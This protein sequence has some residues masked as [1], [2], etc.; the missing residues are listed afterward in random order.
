MEPL[1]RVADG[2]IGLAATIGAIGL[3]VEIG[4]ILTDV[5]GRA[6]GSPLL[7]SQDFITM[8]LVIVVFGGMAICDRRGG[9]V[10]VDILEHRY[11]PALNR[12]IDIVAAALGAVIFLA[13]A[14]AV[15]E[16]AKLSV[17]LNLATNIYTLPKAWFQWAL[18]GFAVLTAAAMALRALELAVTGRDVRKDSP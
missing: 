18:C 12:L 9:H 3:W 13:I 6:L 15:W 5:V 4:V 14:W 17:M 7:G 8:T 16:S 1:R 10:A 2:L 11:P